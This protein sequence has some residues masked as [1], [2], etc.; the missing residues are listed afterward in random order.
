MSNKI[1]FRKSLADE[2]EYE[3]AHCY[4]DVVEHRTDINRGDYV[5]PRYSSLP[6]Y[7]S[8]DYDITNLH[9]S[10]IQSYRQ[11][12][13]IA[14]FEWYSNPVLKGHTP[15]SWTM[16]EF[17]QAPE[18]AYIV[19][20]AT[21]SKKWNWNTS[22]FAEDKKAATLVMC[23]L[24][25]DQLICHQDIIFRE[26]VPLVTFEIGINGMRFTEEF[27]YFFVGPNLIDKGYY[28]SI[29]DNT[30]IPFNV[31]CDELAQNLA[32]ECAKHTNFFVLDVAMTEAGYPLLIEINCGTMSGLSCIDPFVFYKQLKYRLDN[33][34]DE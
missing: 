25:E 32:T 11:H 9:G 29:A 21:N 16:E 8:L 24:L 17:A 5:I 22:M 34:N 13:W 31:Q 1:L 2:D 20:G 18:Q 27:R 12:K 14:D 15:K 6:F 33:Y 10:L 28:W 4:F 30:D 26:Y 23:N 3:A 19:K 7:D